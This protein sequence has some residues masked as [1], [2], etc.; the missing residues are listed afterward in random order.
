MQIILNEEEAKAYQNQ[1]I[2]EAILA[3]TSKF[4]ANMKL[5]QGCKPR[6]IPLSD[7]EKAKIL[8]LHVDGMARGQI[9]RELHLPGRQ[10]SG[11]IQGHLHPIA[12]N[13][14]A[15][16]D[17]ES[18][19]MHAGL[20]QAPIIEGLQPMKPLIM[21]VTEKPPI[22]PTCASCGKPLGRDKVAIGGKMYC[23]QACAPKKIPAMQTKRIKPPKSNS[24]IDS[25]IV[26]VSSKNQ[27][28]LDIA[29]EINR[30]FGGAW[31]PEHVTKRLE[32]LRSHE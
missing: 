11:F 14:Q 26:D 24:A 7:D 25:L 30:V 17:R 32:E 20:H 5:P 3:E 9:A 31:L 6:P 22:E 29:N 4:P 13:V 18:V 19:K 1:K 12:T 23:G 27:D 15:A 2:R 16:L 21:P 28:P 10:V 8:K